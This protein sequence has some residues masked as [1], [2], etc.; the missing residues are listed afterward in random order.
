M[1]GAGGSRALSGTEVRRRG[2]QRRSPGCRYRRFD[3][4]CLVCRPCDAFARLCPHDRPRSARGDLLASDTFGR[5]AGRRPPRADRYP[6]RTCERGLRARR[7]GS[8]P[9]EKVH[10][11]LP[12]SAVL[13]RR[14]GS[15]VERAT[16]L[17]NP[18]ERRRPTSAELIVLIGAVMCAGCGR[19]EAAK[20][21]A[22]ASAN[23]IPTVAV[24]KASPHNLSHDLALT[25]EFR[26]YQEI[27]VMAKVSGYVKKIDVDIGDHVREGQLLA[28]LEIPEMTDELNKARAEIE[29]SQAQVTQAQD[30]VRRAQSG[31]QIANLSYRRLN[32]VMQS[33]PGLVAQQEVDDAQARETTADAQVSAAKSNVS[34]AQNQVAV[35]RAE[36][37]RVQTLF[38]YTKVTAPFDGA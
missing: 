22:T 37:A 17:N 26:P 27:D 9:K 1:P 6:S 36:L 33:R 23:E 28:T 3:G 13:P 7:R 31:Y 15:P 32:G 20:A 4:L 10:R 29:R 12:V 2:D 14:S 30:E 16:D 11:L 35:S 25:G 19:T 24:A 8:K 38:D 34:A 5:S 18:H 21:R